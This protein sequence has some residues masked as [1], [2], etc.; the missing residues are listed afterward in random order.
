MSA[1]LCAEAIGFTRDGRSV[2]QDVSMTVRT[3]EMVALLGANGSGK[4]TLL[5][6]LLGLLAPDQ[7]R[8]LLDDRPISSLRRREVARRIAYVPQR[9]R[10]VFPYRVR[11]I[12]SMGRSPVVGWGGTEPGD[13]TVAQAL[14]R[15]RIPHLA[16]RPY[17]ALSGGE[18]QS[19]LIARALA[20]AAPI[21]LLDEPSAAL[22]P[23][24][25]ERLIGTLCTLA[26]DGVAILASIHEP[27]VARRS[28]DRAIV[29]GGGH[30]LTDGPAEQTL[31]PS[32]LA[33][34]YS[35]PDWRQ[36]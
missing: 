21:L 9:H 34:A 29:L 17:N 18:Q 8:V 31:T 1:A 32:L 4:T 23:G 20:Q 5:R 13:V 10:A 30:V 15:A 12:V 6:L 11:E 26:Q 25:R 33:Q 7:G 36:G 2:L 3:G 16:E 35:L 14:E 27:D 22:D 19:V 28:F 24:Q